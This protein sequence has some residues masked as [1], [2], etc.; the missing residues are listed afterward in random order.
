MPFQ[1]AHPEVLP[2][3]DFAEDAAL[4]VL[5]VSPGDVVVL[6]TDGLWDNMW[7]TQ[8]LELVGSVIR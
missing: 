4:D 2:D 5:E 3:T 6:G 7:D 8:L 1:M